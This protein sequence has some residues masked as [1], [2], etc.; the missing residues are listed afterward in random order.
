MMVGGY[1]DIRTFHNDSDD[2]FQDF[3]NYY[4]ASRM[5]QSGHSFEIYGEVAQNFDPTVEQPAAGSLFAQTSR[6]SG[7]KDVDQFD[8]PPTLPDLLVPIAALPYSTAMFI[9]ESLNV[10]ALLFAGIILTRMI[11]IQSFGLASV[12][13]VALG[14]FRPTIIAYFYGNLPILLLFLVLLGYALY[15]SGHKPGAGFVFALAIA[16][17]LTPL[18]VIVPFLAWR[19]WKILRVVAIWLILLF[20]ALLVINGPAALSMYFFHEMPNMGTKLLSMVD[21]NLSSALQV[22]LFGLKFDTPLQG[23][24]WIAR[25]LSV[26]ILALAVWLSQSERINPATGGSRL[27]TFTIFLLFSCCLSPVSWIHA[28]VLA[29][30]FVLVLGVLAWQ[31]Y[32]NIFENV[33]LLLFVCSFSLNSHP[34]MEMTTPLIGISVGLLRLRRI[35]TEPYPSIASHVIA[36]PQN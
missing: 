23:L 17:K 10:V 35:R 14:V 16:I 11:G 24:I 7:L 2:F 32:A 6:T 18:I 28:Y 34:R 8:A 15:N 25:F 36:A 29:A 21:R 30:P 9:W 22:V 27:E 3:R 31:G 1:S 12:L 19:D 26:V 5:V 33:L 20:G 13:I 4:V